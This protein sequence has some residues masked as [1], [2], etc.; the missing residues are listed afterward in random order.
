MGKH[1][2][3][4]SL[5][6]VGLILLSIVSFA[7]LL[8][9]SASAVSNVIKQKVN[10]SAVISC[11]DNGH[12]VSNLSAGDLYGGIENFVKSGNNVYVSTG[13]G[14]S[15]AKKDCQ[16]IVSEALASK[17]VSVPDG[18]TSS[19]D[20]GKFLSNFGYT[21]SGGGSGECISFTYENYFG[22]SQA[23]SY[24]TNKLCAT[25]NSQGA[26]E[27][28][29][30]SDDGNT[31]L[32][33]FRDA[34]DGSVVV[35]CNGSSAFLTGGCGEVTF[36]KG[37]TKWGDKDSGFLKQVRDMVIANRSVID[38]G[39]GL[40]MYLRGYNQAYN[41]V[42]P[43]NKESAAV[44]NAEYTLTVDENSK[45]K[46][47]QY[48]T[49]AGYGNK[50]TFTEEEQFA[51]YQDYLL[52]Y[53]QAEVHCDWNADM[54]NANGGNGYVKV[55]L[56]QGGSMKTCYVKKGDHKFFGTT[57][58]GIDANH[59]YGVDCNFD[60]VVEWLRDSSVDEIKDENNK[61]TDPQNSSNIPGGTT[62]GKKPT[63]GTTTTDPASVTES[64]DQ[65]KNCDELMDKALKDGEKIGSMQWILCPS[66]DNTKYTATW[67]DEMTDDWL[68]MDPKTYSDGAVQSAWDA[69]RNISNTVMIIFLLVIIFSQLTGYGIDNYGVKKMLPRLITMAI[70]V[71]LS[72]FI[73]VAAA[74]LSNIFGSGLRN[75][76]GALGNSNH[77]GDP[78]YLGGAAVGMF[79]AAGGGGSAAIGAGVTAASLGAS[80]AVAIIIAVIV[81]ALI[82][83]VAVMVLFLM[84][85]VRLI[86]VIICIILSP[87]AFASFILPNTQSIF[88]K[89]WDAYKAA[90]IIYPIC[91][92][93]AGIS[94]LLRS[95]F[96]GMDLP[97][98]VMAIAMIMPYLGFFLIPTLL[99]SAIAALGKFGGALT[100]MGNSMRNGGRVMGHAAA[101]MVKNSEGYKNL[102]NETA[103][104]RQQESADRTIKRLEKI[105]EKNGNLSD[106][107][108]RR[109]ARAHETMR[110]LGNEDHAARTILAN[111]EYAGLA[112]ESDDPK[113]RT[114]MGDWKAAWKA[115]DTEKMNALTDVIVARHGPGGVS[116]M[117][118]ALAGDDMKVFD[119][120]GEFIG[121]ENGA[122]AR[123][124]EAFRLNMQQN[125]ALATGMQNK[126]S[127]AFQMIS[128]GGYVQFKKQMADGSV[129]TVTQRANLNVH[130]A[131]NNIAT[132]SKDWATQST[133]TIRRA[134]QSGALKQE[135]VMAL[136]NSSDPAIQSGFQSD[137]GKME[138]AQ[139]FVSNPNIDL[140]D[141]AAVRDE[142]ERYASGKIHSEALEANQE[143][144]RRAEERQQIRQQTESLSQAAGA[145]THMAGSQGQHHPNSTPPHPDEN[146]G[147]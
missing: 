46:G 135:D 63:S 60:C 75:L 100:A 121:G 107:Q 134:I 30:V 56:S 59:Q 119:D 132:Q 91:G 109:L 27:S 111:K 139:A 74:D 83:L 69:I 146:G 137:A 18:A 89:W 79:A 43:M 76:F 15:W 140:N 103:R 57:V 58:G 118:S 138:L 29:T 17:N 47:T 143:F 62:G 19:A 112:L 129:Q 92:L 114:L 88:K 84:L 36:Q 34:D 38:T 32:M 123:S 11:Y 53:Y 16:D 65:D 67:I 95:I 131:N 105:K 126:A 93:L 124:F 9:K 122:P 96:K 50:P 21:T 42:D 120:N 61:P 127:D 31:T 145:L 116:T 45:K 68:L 8:P 26:I 113:Q 99:K 87:L 6:W 54:A 1:L 3:K 33:R 41:G 72:W 98:G 12:F 55:K 82:I 10:A 73:C 48:L 144:N 86:I 101:G 133:A 20:K 71:N 147:D 14:E 80:A 25:L 64:E 4:K 51:L 35:D 7:I 77:I 37:V 110:K 115:G 108:T 94:H 90:L 22:G 125:N 13:S 78:S 66:M 70:L 24:T 23:N 44:A 5:L 49:G 104:R 52:N 39:H 136:M 117:A 106:T 142:A 2:T 81:L 40:K 28:L 85:G 97:M 102:Q 130:S 128:G 141:K